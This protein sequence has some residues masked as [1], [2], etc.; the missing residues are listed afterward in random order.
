MSKI[1]VIESHFSKNSDSITNTTLQTFINEYKKN[2]S[3]D[4][5][6]FLNLNDEKELHVILNTNNMTTFWNEK[7]NEWIKLVNDADKII[8]T[9]SMV[10]F[11]ISPILK[12]FFD[13]ILIAGKTF[14]YKYTDGKNHSEGLINPNKKALL[15]MSQGSSDGCYQFAAFDNYVKGVLNF[16]GINNVDV[17]LI[18]GT[19]ENQQANLTIQ[20]KIDRKKNEINELVKKF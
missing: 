2:N 11:F 15:I 4:E 18:D 20:E 13:K 6:I 19:K 9:T 1:L 16:I 7:S 3:S 12:N 10:N 5:F 8:I 14:R 17:I